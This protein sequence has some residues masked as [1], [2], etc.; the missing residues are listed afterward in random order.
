ME[1]TKKQ[2]MSNYLS[3]IQLLAPLLNPEIVQS[4]LHTPFAVSS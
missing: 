4:I 2:T 1:K 3:V